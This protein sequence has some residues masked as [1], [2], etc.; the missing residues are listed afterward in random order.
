MESSDRAWNTVYSVLF[1]LLCMKES[2]LILQSKRIARPSPSPS[3]HF[4]VSVPNFELPKRRYGR[5]LRNFPLTL[6]FCKRTE[7]AL[8]F[9]TEFF[10]FP[11]EDYRSQF[12]TTALS[13]DSYSDVSKSV[14]CM[15]EEK[16]ICICI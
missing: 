3:S 1:K 16:M 6:Q 9:P 12:P 11:Y 4:E 15:K 10:K 14:G 5:D 7:D 13:W 2:N 8:E